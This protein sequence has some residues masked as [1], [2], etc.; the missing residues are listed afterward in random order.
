MTMIWFG[1]DFWPGWASLYVFCGSML[2]LGLAHM[3][4]LAL[5]GKRVDESGLYFMLHVLANTFICYVA[6]PDTIHVLCHPLDGV[7]DTESLSHATVRM[8]KTPGTPSYL[9]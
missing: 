1:V 2:G 7:Q 8:G 6:L 9:R 5:L 3:V 4:I